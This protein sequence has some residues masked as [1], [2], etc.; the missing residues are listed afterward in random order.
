MGKD[1]R[2]SERK[3]MYRVC[4]YRIDQR[5]YAD[6]STNISDKGIF[7]KNFAPPPVGTR[8]QI[9]AVLSEQ[10]GNLPVTF[11]GRVAW[12]DNGPDPHRR[13][14]GIEFESI[15]ADSLP[16]IRYFVNEV[17]HQTGSNQA[18]FKPISLPEDEDQ[19]P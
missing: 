15:R 5:D 17:Y 1:K 6:L 3:A 7:I 9:S 19:S 12:I 13:G 16:I 8:V 14:M 18:R 11:I 2:R 4:R 10:W